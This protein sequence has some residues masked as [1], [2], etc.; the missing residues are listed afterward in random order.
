M[1][2]SPRLDLNPSAAA[3]WTVCTASPHFILRNWDKVPE[4][5]DTIY[6]REGTLAHAV[7]AAMLLKQPEPPAM[8]DALPVIEVT[9]EM[10]WHGWE[11][12]EYVQG[13]REPGST[14]L[15]EEKLPLWYMPGRN[16]IVDAAVINRD[17]LHIVDYKYGAGVVVH[18]ER[19][20][21][22]VIYAQSVASGMAVFLEEKMPVFIHIYQPRG[23]AGE[24]GPGHVWET[25]YGE[26][27]Q[28]AEEISAAAKLIIESGDEEDADLR[29]TVFAPSDKACQW[30]PAKGFC[31]ARQMSL[32]DGFEVLETKSVPPPPDTLTLD[33]RARIQ[34][35]ASAMKAWLDDVV[36]Y[37]QL[38]MEQGE[39]LPGFKLVMSR[40]GNRYWA[41]PKKAAELLV[42]TT[43]L[44]REEVIEEST[45]SP[46]AAEKLLGKNKFDVALTNLITKAPGKPTIA[47]AADKRQ[48]IGESAVSAFEIL[49]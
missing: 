37:N 7:A 27:H 45:I 12:A 4:S 14:L 49:P 1:K 25:T 8:V 24:T 42:S 11:Y 23:R 5:S 43:H 35:H 39:Q 48:A 13:L 20:L 15:V 18:P 31:T 10:R 41:D 46:A 40:G 3:R 38:R 29:Q 44:R 19:S 28:I 9:P 36:E 30:C 22:A 34:H 26:V 16:A 33:Q 21:Q 2:R 47:P 6:N 32:A 17:S